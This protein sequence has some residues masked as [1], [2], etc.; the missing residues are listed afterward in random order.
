M[1]RRTPPNRPA[2]HRG[3]R[4][5]SGAER[6]APTNDRRGGLPSV[7]SGALRTRWT[8][9]RA[10]NGTQV[11]IPVKIN[12][13]RARIVFAGI[14]SGKPVWD[15]MDLVTMW[16]AVL[17]NDFLTI[18]IGGAMYDERPVYLNEVHYFAGAPAEILVVEE[19]YDGAV[20]PNN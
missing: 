18:E 1:N 8:R 4:P 16:P 11:P 12:C 2:I 15:G 3:F 13:W 10:E 19:F 7:G 9:Y 17:D 20:Q 14:K 6:A 5:P